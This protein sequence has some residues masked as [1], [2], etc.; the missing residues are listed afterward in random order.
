MDVAVLWY[1]ICPDPDAAATVGT[2]ILAAYAEDDERVNRTVGSLVGRLA[3]SAVDCR[4]LSYPGTRHA[5]HDHHR[6]DRHHSAAA[7]HLW[8]Q[9]LA[10]LDE[11]RCAP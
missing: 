7:D 3:G 1:G 8:R 2:R 4:L 10:F 9:T 5:F 6:P 11:W